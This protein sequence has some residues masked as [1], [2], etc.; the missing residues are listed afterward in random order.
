MYTFDKNTINSRFEDMISINHD[1]KEHKSTLKT[2]VM[3]TDENGVVLFHGPN[4]TVF[5]GR[6]SL[7]ETSFGLVPDI[8][9][10][11]TLN[12]I[13]GIPHADST[14]V[15][16]QK[17]ARSTQYF[18][19]GNGAE[20]KSV[21]GKI[22]SP[23]NYETK[24][25]SPVPFRCVPVASDLSTASQ[26]QYRFKKLITVDSADYYAYYA[27]KYDVGVAYIEYNGASY[28]PVEGDTIP[29]DEGD[30][31]HPLGG[32][33]VLEYVQF[34]LTIEKDEFKEYYRLLHNDSLDGAVL[35]EIGLLYGADRANS[36][37]NNRLELAAA[38]LF[39]KLTSTSVPM[40]T[41]GSR[42]IVSYRV[43]A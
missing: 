3:I 38:E 21:A 29:V 18:M 12:S 4:M 20:S 11:L 28:V 25:Y 27:K 36:L 26:D 14:N 30:T 34:T 32:G 37:A 24:L 15:I 6:L 40:N 35:N 43:Y 19:I 13:M 2:D 42:R 22:Y 39:A 10:H 31:S 9:Q 41:E 33:S 23:H 1:A 7:L 8:N 5:G 16:N 17:I